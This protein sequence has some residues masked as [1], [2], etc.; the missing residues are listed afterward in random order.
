MSWLIVES[1]SD[2]S[3]IKSAITM[4]NEKKRR[5]KPMPLKISVG[6]TWPPLVWAAEAQ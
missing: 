3:S 1:D 4:I 2:E 5:N 6:P